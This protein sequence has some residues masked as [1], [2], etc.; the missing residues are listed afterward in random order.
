MYKVLITGASGF[1]GT[2]LIK[3]YV[4]KNFKVL[5]LD[6]LPPRNIS[7]LE[8]WKKTDI[9]DFQKLKNEVLNFSPDFIIHLAARTD[10]DSESIE[11]YKANTDGVSNMIKVS[12]LCSN[13]KRII[14]TSSMLVCEVGYS[15]KDENDYNP[16]NAYGKSKV[17][18][19]L[20]VRNLKLNYEWAIIRPT[21][22]WG[23]WFNKPY[24][25]FFDMIMRN[26]YFHIGNK[27]CLKTY[28]YIGNT[29]H[30]INSILF[31]DK[32]LIQGNVFYIGD[33][34]SYNIEEWGN[35]I[36]AELNKKIIKIPFF[37]IQLAALFGD[38]IKV[39]KISFP[40]TSFRLNNMTTN[41]IVEL[42]SI[43]GLAKN[44]PY[45]RLE[46]I[47]ITVKWLKTKV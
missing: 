28:G 11:D 2:N 43:K 17:Q 15:P 22:I 20:I 30:Q 39:F 12:N 33:Y 36:A 29:I 14:F 1:I 6:I 27:S 5:N 41:N 35:E 47:K 8:Y 45:S 42:N 10:L 16:I 9:L 46:G 3:Y 31:A 4:N 24:R 13:L 7:H 37:I 38:F 34:T 21:S 19:E 23:P 40:I 44:L 32:N 25:T 18:T 26:R